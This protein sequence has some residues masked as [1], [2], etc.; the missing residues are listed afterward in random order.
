MKKST[1]EKSIVTKR[2]LDLKEIQMISGGRGRG[3]GRNQSQVLSVS[4]TARG[5]WGVN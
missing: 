5:R 4:I 2:P 1:V 3:R